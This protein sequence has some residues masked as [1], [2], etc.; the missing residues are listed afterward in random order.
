[1][2]DLGDGN[3][4]GGLHGTAPGERLAKPVLNLTDT[5]GHP[6]DLRAR[7]AGKVTLLFFGYTHCPDVCP[8]TMADIAAAL[9]EVKPDVRAQVAVVFVSTDPDRDTGAVL[10]RWLKQFNPAFIGVRGPFEQVRTE[11]EAL[12]V[13]LEKPK[14]Q[15]DGSVLVTHGAQVIAFSRDDKIRALYLAGTGVQA[16]IDDLPTLTAERSGSEART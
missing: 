10:S 12:G 15:A 3:G 16:Y 1:M 2:V 5:D 4:N 11:A 14:V 6:F 8:T 7:T 13:P 9:N